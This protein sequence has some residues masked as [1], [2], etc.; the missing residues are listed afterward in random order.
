MNATRVALNSLSVPNRDLHL[1][2]GSFDHVGLCHPSADYHVAYSL[3]FD[4][5]LVIDDLL[6]GNLVVDSYFDYPGTLD[7]VGIIADLAVIS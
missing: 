3:S 6:V 1:D 7:L 4:I 2:F 5:D